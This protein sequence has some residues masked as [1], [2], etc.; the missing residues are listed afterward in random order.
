MLAAERVSGDWNISKKIL[1]AFGALGVVGAIS[2][3]IIIGGLALTA[4][5]AFSARELTLSGERVGA[6]ENAV[7]QAQSSIK[8]YV[9]APSSALER[10][11]EAEIAAAKTA[12]DDID[13]AAETAGVSEEVSLLGKQLSAQRT[14]FHK[15]VK[16]QDIIS[17]RHAKTIDEGGPAI[18]ERL[19]NIVDGAF[20]NGS[21]ATSHRAAAALNH[22]SVARIY[23]NA[24][25][26]SSNDA[27]ID[28]AK[29][30]LLDLEDDMN[31]LFEMISSPA[32]LSEADAVIEDVIAYDQAFDEIV[33][34]TR[35]RDTSVD[36]LL[37][38][39]GPAFDRN[40]TVIRS[41][42]AAQS[43]A[44][45][46]R[47]KFVF[48]TMLLLLIPLFIIGAL[49]VALSWMVSKQMIATPIANLS[50]LMRRLATGDTDV[51]IP[52]SSRHDEIGEMTRAVIVFQKNAHEVARQRDAAA[53]AK[54]REAELEATRQTERLADRERAEEVKR[55][56]LT[57]L[58]DSFE[59]SVRSVAAAVGSAA[60]QIEMGAQQVASAANEN[61]LVTADVATAAHQSSQNALAVANAS[62][63]MARSLAEVSAQVIESSGKSQAASKRAIATDEVVAGLAEDASQIGE[64]V[65]LIN[66]IAEQ[67]NLLALNATIEAARAGDAGRGF[68]VVAGE[69]KALASQTSKA[70][71]Q[72]GERI[73]GIQRVS[74]E[75]VR[76]IEEIVANIAD[77]DGIAA[78][79]AT[80][81]EEQSATTSEIASNTQQAAGGTEMVAR[82]IE[83]VRDGIEET[84]AQ[85]QQSLSAAAELSA[86]AET[87]QRE[88]DNFLARVRAA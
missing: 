39:V 62:E 74:G 59:S 63:E 55:A 19:L 82:N 37:N 51:A 53:A 5:A 47:A 36:S 28:R 80:A 77:I 4:S 78:A 52:E 71:T 15:I 69:I 20:E 58:A 70:T 26:S 85:A 16:A 49:I 61:A 60:R 27:L 6:A 83:R 32:L 2:V 24:Y 12:I 81:V 75:A 64:I 25:R 29:Q 3:I 54:Q 21:H 73:G 33:K 46:N 42:I 31:D 67:T 17:G 1:V 66:D 22:Y 76:A 43:E 57:E 41:E 87:L 45:M 50:L 30:G 35:V 65:E 48:T 84:G 18:G 10:K 38:D 40:A 14:D 72:I 9:I 88:V 56:A 23:V 34:M 8:D 11:V 86:Q 13:D 7:R 79:V 68:A 44:A